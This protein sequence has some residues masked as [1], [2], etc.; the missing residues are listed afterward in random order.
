MREGL[1]GNVKVRLKLR[2]Y[3]ACLG[4]GNGKLR[5]LL[6]HRRDEYFIVRPFRLQPFLKPGGNAVSTARCGVHEEMVF[7]EPH[8]DAV[9]GEEAQLIHHQAIAAFADF[10]RREGVGVHAVEE[11]R[12]IRPLDLDL[13]ERGGIEQ[14][15]LVPHAEDFPVDGA[16]LVFAGLG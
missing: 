15:H 16:V 3:F 9:I 12:R 6:G 14:P 4:P 11:L 8:R 1:V 10:E 5:P 2:Q 13:A 7:T